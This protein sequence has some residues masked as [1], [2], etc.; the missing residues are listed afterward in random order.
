MAKDGV[1]FRFKF[2]Q[3][4][5]TFFER[6]APKLLETARTRAV[7]S[8]GMVWADET[9]DIT[10]AEDHID[11]GL[12]VNSIGY[13]TGSPSNPLYDLKDRNNVA[14]LRIGADVEYAESLEKRYSLM[15]RGIDVGKNRMRKAAITQVKKTLFPRG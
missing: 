8:A 1:K 2:D 6:T 7:E 11:T 15:V 14:T 9:K 3:R 4:T 13:S 5:L 10:T 12:Y